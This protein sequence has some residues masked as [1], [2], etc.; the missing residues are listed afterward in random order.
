[1]PDET[2][3]VAVSDLPVDARQSFGAHDYV[4]RA[5]ALSSDDELM[6]DVLL[7][8]LNESKEQALAALKLSCWE[9]DLSADPAEQRELLRSSI[10][11]A[12]APHPSAGTL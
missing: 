2:E 12:I 3:N 8:L 7:S 10:A 9:E 6:R 1:M 4:I 11:F 5:A